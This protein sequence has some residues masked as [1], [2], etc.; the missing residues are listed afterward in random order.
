MNEDEKYIKARRRVKEIKGFYSHLVVYLVVN[1]FLAVMNFI[2]TP[3]HL[4]FYWVTFG[5]GIGVVMNAISVFGIGGVFGHEWE[6]KKIKDM[7][8]KD[9][10]DKDNSQQ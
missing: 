5:W 8:D 10:M 9:K 4:W 2:T 3:D 7:M 6:E 1:I